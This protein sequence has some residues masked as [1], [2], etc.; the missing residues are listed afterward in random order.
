MKRQ[1]LIEKIADVLAD[2]WDDDHPVEPSG[3]QRMLA[4]HVAEAIDPTVTWA[5]RDFVAWIPVGTVA[6]LPG[7][8]PVEKCQDGHWYMPRV[9]RPVDALF[10]NQ[11]NY[12]IRIVHQ[13]RKEP[14]G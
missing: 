6:V 4:G 11:A 14:N 1:D 8:H 13:P 10:E 7:G 9:D 3:H 2:H 5:H 12:P